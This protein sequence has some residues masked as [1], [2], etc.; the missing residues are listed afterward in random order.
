MTPT[1]CKGEPSFNLDISEDLQAC[2]KMMCSQA[3]LVSFEQH[4]QCC[5]QTQQTQE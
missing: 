3:D 2:A 1:H 5:P 4:I